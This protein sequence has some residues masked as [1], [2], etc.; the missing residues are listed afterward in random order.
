MGR[1]VRG[2]VRAF[3]FGCTRDFKTAGSGLR[4]GS[5]QRQC[6]R[7]Y[8]VHSFDFLQRGQAGHVSNTLYSLCLTGDFVTQSASSR[9]L[10]Q[11]LQEHLE[12]ASFGHLIAGLRVSA[13]VLAFRRVLGFR[14]RRCHMTPAR[15]G[16]GIFGGDPI[17][18]QAREM[19]PAG[20]RLT[21]PNLLVATADGDENEVR[22][23][24]AR[25]ADH[26]KSS[27]GGGKDLK[28]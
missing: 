14:A 8:Q 11:P 7:V 6:G 12:V 20:R 24:L 1:R 13:T 27:H 4:L 18:V 9:I 25:G 3:P 17:H 10:P 2:A 15:R 16:G 22:L 23:L 28:S 19:L 21:D 26:R 5:L